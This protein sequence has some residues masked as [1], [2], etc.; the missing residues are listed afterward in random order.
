MKKLLLIF[1][2]LT[3]TSTAYAG[4]GH[5]HG[6]GAFAGGT[7]PATHFKLTDRQ[8]SNLGIASEKVEFLP[9]TQTVTMLAFTELLPEKRAQVS[10]RFG[11]KILNIDVKV[12]Q[13]VKKGQRLVTLEPIRVGNKNVTLFAPMNGFIIRLNAGI[14]EIVDAGD[15]ILEIGEASQMLVRGMAYETPDINTVK[16]G[17][18]VE[19]HLDIAPERH[20]DGKVQRINRVIDPESRTFS[21]FALIDTPKKNIQPGLQGTIEIFTGSDTPVLSV[22]KRSV[23]GELGSYFVYVLKDRDVEKRDVTIGAKTGH[24]IEIKSG[25][26]PNEHVVTRGNYQ[27]QYMS[28]GGIREHTDDNDDSHDDGHEQE[29]QPQEENNGLSGHEH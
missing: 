11:G 26:F 24:H 5:D 27:L 22:P 16:V 10:P 18:G 6:E 13:E 23:L 17:N 8:M 12:G 3:I 28:L 4:A 2:L 20:I 7:G 1:A 19:V 25:L 15:Q 29:D 14:G 9:I 21:V